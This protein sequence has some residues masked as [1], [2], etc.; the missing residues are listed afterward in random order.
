GKDISTAKLGYVNDTNY[1][2]FCYN[3]YGPYTGDL[4]CQGSNN[5]ICYDSDY[6]PKIGI[7][8]NFIVENY[9]VFQVIR[10]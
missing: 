10:Q 6:Y 2:I 8:G 4:Y 3:N 7:S 1:A 5:W 9:E